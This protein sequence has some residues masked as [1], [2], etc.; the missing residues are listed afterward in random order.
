MQ[1]K[2]NYIH[3]ND[4][5]A[6][7]LIFTCH[8]IVNNFYQD[9]RF[10]LIDKLDRRMWKAVYLPKL[11]LEKI[12]NFWKRVKAI[13]DVS[14]NGI[15]AKELTEL[16]Q[17]IVNSIEF[18]NTGDTTRVQN[19]W[20]GIV[21]TGFYNDL[22]S[23]FSNIDV[24]EVVVEIRITTFGT[25]GSFSPA[26]IERNK[27]IIPV[28]IRSDNRI[29]SVANLIISS[30]V[31]FLKYDNKKIGWQDEWEIN[32]SITDFFK[33]HTSLSKYL[34]NEIASMDHIHDNNI[35]EKLILESK[36]YY[37]DLGFPIKN[38]LEFKNKNI[39]ILGKS[40]KVP[41]SHKEKIILSTLVVNRGE[42]ISFNDMGD[43]IW[44]GQEDKYSLWAMSKLVEKTRKK[45]KENGIYSEILQTVRKQGY[46]LY[47]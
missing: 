25:T 42:V 3:G 41:F 37:A 29:E 11:E 1:I 26:R 16:K 27:L 44:K 39:K 10:L 2:T 4:I 24:K 8:Q 35:S 9:K 33:L 36:Q 19:E 6:L 12:P 22:F 23:I 31:S 47:D 15:E 17:D 14:L 40:P 18:K 21:K 32:Q 34:P 45:L 20:E 43:I 38:F 5:E 13:K 28:V 7:R 30:I 46:V